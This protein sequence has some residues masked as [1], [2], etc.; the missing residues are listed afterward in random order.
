[1][2]QLKATQEAG[3]RPPGPIYL[4]QRLGPPAAK[5]AIGSNGSLAVGCPQAVA[6]LQGSGPT[7]DGATPA[8]PAPDH[9]L[10][11]GPGEGDLL[12]AQAH[13]LPRRS[14]VAPLK[15]QRPFPRCARATALAVRPDRSD[16]GGS[17]QPL[18]PRRSHTGSAA[19]SLCANCLGWRLS[20]R[21]GK[22]QPAASTT[23]HGSTCWLPITFTCS[24]PR[25]LQPWRSKFP[26]RDQRTGPKEGQSPEV[27]EPLSWRRL[28]AQAAAALP[29][30]GA[31]ALGGLGTLETLDSQLTNGSA[32]SD[33]HPAACPLA[34]ETS[35]PSVF[36]IADQAQ[37][38]TALAF[39]GE[40]RVTGAR[41]INSSNFELADHKLPWG[42]EAGR[43]RSLL[44]VSTPLEQP[45]AP[46]PSKFLASSE[47]SAQQRM[48]G[49]CGGAPASQGR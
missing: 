1:L 4:A 20:S 7:P 18:Q 32:P 13:P 37:A 38:A 35:N 28:I 44:K 29:T 5:L 45:G 40:R 49:A 30:P 27:V 31:R 21:T 14:T 25:R 3:H 2:H 10:R 22:L 6:P 47:P 48:Q 15:N 16:R 26:C 33:H 9:R 12:V 46:Q 36:A 24:G 19:A 39:F 41:A 23:C 17:I 8:S 34:S 43:P 11:T 42:L